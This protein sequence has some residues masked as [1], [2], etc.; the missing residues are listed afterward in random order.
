MSSTVLSTPCVTPVTTE[1]CVTVSQASPVILMTAAAAA[2]CLVT[3]ARRM[4]SAHRPKGVRLRGACASVWLCVT[5]LAVAPELYVWPIIMWHSASVRLGY[6][7]G[8]LMI[9]RMAAAPLF[10]SLM[11]TVPQTKHAIDSIILVLMCVLM[12]VVKMQSALLKTIAINASV[13]QVIAHSQWL[14]LPVVSWICVTPTRA[15]HL[16]GAP[17]QAAPI[18][19]C[20]PLEQLVTPT[21]QAATPRACA[22]MGTVT[23]SWTVCV[24][25]AAVHPHVTGPVVPT[26]SAMLS[27]GSPFVPAPQISSQTQLLR[28]AV[29]EPYLYAT[30]THSALM[31]L[32]LQTSAGWCV[33]TMQ[34]VPKVSDA[35]ETSAWC[36]ACH[37][38]SA[39]LDRRALLECVYWAV[40]AM[41]TA[42]RRRA[43]STTSVPTLAPRKM[44]VGP[45]LSVKSRTSVQCASVQWASRQSPLLSKAAFVCPLPVPPTVSV[46]PT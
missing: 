43:V 13:H 10:V 2:H 29:Y 46:A 16:P 14:T 21:P 23:A 15:T 37:P 39:L 5:Q 38:H 36:P 42:H 26:P 35:S 6:S 41:V 25:T 18:S 34:S 9:L 3:S 8:T 1:A 30:V 44:Y 27:T 17:H 32:V 40:A 20:A 12:L 4:P 31:G 33:A 11:K 22:P 7:L 24:S 45:M 19:A 28:V